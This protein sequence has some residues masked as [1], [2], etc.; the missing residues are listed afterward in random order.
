MGPSVLGTTQ[1]EMPAESKEMWIILWARYQTALAILQHR[2]NVER[3]GLIPM[4]LCLTAEI[5]FMLLHP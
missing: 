1:Q 3:R 4:M 2:G 5:L